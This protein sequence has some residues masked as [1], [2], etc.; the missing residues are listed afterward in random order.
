MSMMLCSYCG[1]LTDTDDGG[2]W[3]VQKV[4]S[5]KRYELVCECCVE[6]YLNEA[7]QLDPDLP[8]NLAEAAWEP[9]QT[10]NLECPPVTMQEQHEAAW[11]QKRGIRS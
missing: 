1:D 2:E 7:G 3:D 5:T 8:E 4:N 10:A 9:Q 11:K 6:K